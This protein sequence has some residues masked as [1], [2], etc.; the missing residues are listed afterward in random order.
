M[1]T[2]MIKVVYTLEDLGKI[3]NKLNKKIGIWSI[4]NHGE[5]HNGHRK[6]YEFVKANSTFIVGLIANTWMLQISQISKNPIDPVVLPINSLTIEELKSRCDVVM[7]YDGTYTSFDNPKKMLQLA[8]KSLPKTLLPSF[9]QENEVIMDSLRAAQIFK[10][11]LNEKILYHYHCG[12]LKDPWRFYYAQWQNKLWPDRFYDLIK[13]ATDEFG[14]SISDSYPEVLRLKINKP[15]LVKGMRS[16]EDL[17]N[18][19]KDIKGLNVLYFAY[20]PN[21]HYILA[22][23]HHDDFANKWW[24]VSLED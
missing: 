23:F 15:L 7:I 3:V 21:T 24:N 4:G 6:C 8:E 10:M 14:Q 13:P 18:N 20:D 2:N 22:R 16:I 5:I 12:S 11:I 9:I 19:V 1:N 17:K